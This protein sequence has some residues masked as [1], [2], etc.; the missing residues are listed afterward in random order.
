M[1]GEIYGE[2]N[3]GVYDKLR[4]MRNMLYYGKFMRYHK[5]TVVLSYLSISHLYFLTNETYTNSSFFAT[6]KF[7][8]LIIW[9]VALHYFFSPSSKRSIVCVQIHIYS[10]NMRG[11][12]IYVAP[13]WEKYLSKH[14]LIKHACSWPV[15]RIIL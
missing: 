13:R 6:V 10:L 12:T 8:C 15:K 4:N 3:E 7:Y 5:F 11:I 1:Y 14:S 2:A 9:L